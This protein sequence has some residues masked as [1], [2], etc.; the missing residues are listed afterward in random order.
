M[1]NFD[2]HRFRC[3]QIGD[4]LT[5]GKSEITPKQMET[6]SELIEK[7][8]KKKLTDKQE[9][10][11]LRLIHKRDNPDL[12]ATCKTKLI[13]IYVSTRFNRDK[14]IFNK[15]VEKGLAVEEDSITLLS[16][17]KGKYLKKNTE[18]IHNNYFSGEPDI[19]EG[20]DIYHAYSITD[21]KSSWDI[22]TYYSAR[23]TRINE[24]YKWQLHGYMDISG[25]EKSNLAYCLINTPETIINKEVNKMMWEMGATTSESPEF[26]EAKEELERS[27][28]FD[29]IPMIERSF[30][31]F[32]PREEWRI[33]AAHERVKECRV[34]LNE[35]H[36][37]L[38]AKMPVLQ[39]E[40]F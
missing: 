22:H 21:I 26:L 39:E 4:L 20:E 36:E 34:W 32:V 13:E 30:D 38:T 16:L 6:I 8:S 7:Q 15:Y 1:A 35:L 9:K 40:P 11:L 2:N 31:Q 28:R 33:K 37:S 17:N 12:S 18:R 27:M 24:R 3:H 25:A 5:E 14:D 29:D 19:Y 10:E 23:L